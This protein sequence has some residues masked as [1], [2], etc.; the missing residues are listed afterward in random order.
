MLLASP[1]LALE[2]GGR[3]D[4]FCDHGQDIINAELVG[5]D[6]TRYYVKLSVSVNKLPI[7]KKNVLR[8]VLKAAPERAKQKVRMH[9][10]FL[11]GFALASG[12][13]SDFT[14][15][16]PAA[17]L[18]GTYEV[19]PRLGLILRADF[20][21]FASGDA[22]LSAVTALPGF[23]Y[24][25]PW[26]I[27]RIRV[28]AG[29]ALGTAWLYAF[30]DNL[31]RHSFTPAALVFFTAAYDF[32]DRLAAVMSVDTAYLYDVQTAVWIPSLKIGVGYRL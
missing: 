19:M 4:F 12:R 13:L 25:L 18:Y 7:E 20:M 29:M 11:G 24:E 15:G 26:H 16:A 10:G 2:T 22:A 31:S 3:Y 28:S 21:R 6:E 9:A 1:V 30:A 23:A 32:S 5:E 8:T 14:G 17:T 27:W